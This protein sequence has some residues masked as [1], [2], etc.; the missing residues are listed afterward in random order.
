[1]NILVLNGPNLNLLGERDSSLY[2]TMTLAQLVR[3]VTSH[4]RRRG[5]KVRARQSNSEGALIDI[6][7]SH[8][9][10]ADA[11][12]FNPGAY[13]HYSYALRDAVAAICVPTIEV[14][15]S[16]VTKREPFRRV[17]VIEPVCAGRRFGKGLQSYFEAIDV[18]ISLNRRESSRPNLSPTGVY[19]TG[20]R[21]AKY[22][23]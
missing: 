12:V 3:E 7:H 11:I 20:L 18:L 8:R 10:W 6:L 19:A 13:T 21:M 17:S 15:L 4:A 9:K 23:K 2:G 5:A 14:H 16:N 1:M 22:K